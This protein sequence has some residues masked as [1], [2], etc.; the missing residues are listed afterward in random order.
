MRE[1]PASNNATIALEKARESMNAL[2]K[3]S[4]FPHEEFFKHLLATHDQSVSIVKELVVEGAAETPPDPWTEEEKDEALERD[5]AKSLAFWIRSIPE[6][7]LDV[8]ASILDQ[9]DWAQLKYGVSIGDTLAED[10]FYYLWHEDENMQGP[11]CWAICDAIREWIADELVPTYL[12]T[13]A[14]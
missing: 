11:V 12:P 5:L 14:A 1:F 8:A 10:L 7:V 3:T 9:F 6:E 13:E 2:C 4:D